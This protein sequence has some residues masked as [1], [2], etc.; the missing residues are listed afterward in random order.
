MR[1]AWFTPFNPK[2]AI[3][4]YSEEITRELARTDSL[5]LYVSDVSP[6]T[7]PRRTALPIV[8]LDDDPSDGLL[9]Q[10]DA[11]DAVVYNMGNYPPFHKRIYEVLSRRPGVVVL[12]DLVLR[13]FLQS[14]YLNDKRDPEGFARQVA[15]S[16]GPASAEAYRTFWEGRSG[17]PDADRDP[18]QSPMFPAVLHRCLGVVVHSEYGRGRVAAATSAPVVKL[19]F[20]P[21]GQCV[22]QARRKARAWDKS[23]AKVRLLTFGYLNRNKQIH[24]VIEAIARSET[25]RTNVHYIIVGEGDGAYPQEL[26]QRWSP[27]AC[28]T[29]SA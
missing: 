20:P 3:G 27:K 16:D 1:I 25:L 26:R 10:L 28:P 21:F 22:G 12:H 23:D 18:L 11:F 24:A 9:R 8:P 4:H 5:V 14:Y 19:D 15:Y 2:S 7:S 13:D 17:D 29:S 6:K